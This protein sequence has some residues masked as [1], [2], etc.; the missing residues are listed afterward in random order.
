M[1]GHYPQV[2][3]RIEVE[4]VTTPAEFAPQVHAQRVT[5]LGPGELPPP[6]RP[7]RD[8]LSNGS[9][10]TQYVEIQGVVTAVSVGGLTLLMPG[11]SLRILLFDLNEVTQRVAAEDARIR[12]RGVVGASFDP[13]TERFKG[14][15]VCLFAPE[16]Q[17][18]ESPPKD[19]FALPPKRVSELLLFDPLANA[20]RHVKVSGQ[21]VCQRD[22]ETYLMDGTNG[23]RFTQRA[24][25]SLASGAVLEVVGFPMW[26][27]P[28]P[29]LREA[30]V[31]QTGR[32]ALPPALGV[33][34]DA[35]FQIEYD[36]VRVRV[37]A[38]LVHATPDGRTLELQTHLRRFVA[39]LDPAQKPLAAMPP[40]SRLQLVGVHAGRGM[41]LTPRAQFDS[42]ELLL[43]SS[44]DVRVLARPAW[45][46]WWRWLGLVVV[47][48]AVLGVA[49]VWIR[50]LRRQV[51]ERTARL[52]AEIRVREQAEHQRSLAQERARIAR[53]LHDDLGSTLTEITMLA[54]PPTQ[55]AMGPGGG[56]DR[57][58][59][60]AQRSRM[61]V[62]ALDATVWA[63]DPR[64][65]TLE[66]LAHYLASYA[67]EC[68][69][70]ARLACRVQIPSTLPER[71]VSG[72][73]RHHVLL[74]VKEA[75]NNAVRHSGASE[76]V[77]RLRV[78]GDWLAIS[79]SDGGRGFHPAAPLEG[80]GL[81]NLEERMRDLGGRC[82]LEAAP[83][84]GTTVSLEIP[85]PVPNP[86]P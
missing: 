3:D 11:G 37:E 84:Q 67:E 59:M 45:W 33:T 7:S 66:S 76:V 42:C 18:E 26:T 48:T 32:A 56:P 61:L 15:E 62:H 51:L 4:G 31:R 43:G 8:E 82:R 73:V 63:V 35:L 36:A 38:M 72:Q 1:A 86:V 74:A 81:R 60:I 27:G 85:L 58:G 25:S 34:G 2:G 21:V 16:I 44:A 57:L 83:D 79:I 46:T 68:L 22:D 9:L 10:H 29:R 71:S 24:F 53:D 19:L 50:L 65:D 41:A 55:A 17:I 75:L 77:F 64:R 13:D 14:G 47:L 78:N 70:G 69:G 80:N 20:L 12:L 39:R 30:V 6:L 40:G 28:T 49:L 52:R 5:R 54:T 23:L